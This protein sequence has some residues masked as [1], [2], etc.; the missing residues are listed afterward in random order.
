VTQFGFAEVQFLEGGSFWQKLRVFN[1]LIKKFRPD[2]VHSVLFEANILGR[3]SRIQQRNFVHLESLVNETYSPHRLADPQ[4]TRLKLAAYRLFDFVTQW[5][6]VDHFHANGLSVAR[7]YRQKLFIA[8]RRMTLI[9]RGRTENPLSGNIAHRE[10]IRHKLQTGDRLLLINVARHE[11][12]KGQD[13]LIDAIAHLKNDQHKIQLL[14]VGRE[15]KLTPVLKEK[16]AAH[17]LEKCVTLLGHRD[18]VPALLAAADVFVFPSRFEGLPGALIEAEAAGL[19]IIASDIPN[20]R[21]VAEAGKNALFFAVNDSRRLAEAIAELVNN[22]VL[23]QQ[24][25][26]ESLRLFRVRYSMEKVHQQMFALLQ[27]LAARA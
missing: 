25:G 16:I 23:R 2:V 22:A 8:T 21:E 27:Q 15:G 10:K 5:A 13:V 24:F 19:P 12:Q 26:A 1:N 14:L 6:G 4:V 20:N 18:D 7:H 9:P 3:F 11:Y 17:G